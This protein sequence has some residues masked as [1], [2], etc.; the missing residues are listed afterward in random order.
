MYNNI[1]CGLQNDL[2]T[3][4]FMFM[5]NSLKKNLLWLSFTKTRFVTNFTHVF[6]RRTSSNLIYNNVFPCA[7]KRDHQIFLWYRFFLLNV[8]VHF[9]WK[10]NP[11]YFRS[12]YKIWYCETSVF[13][14]DFKK[15]ESKQCQPQLWGHIIFFET[16][17]VLE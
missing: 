14:V 6:P 16:P 2:I 9:R 1:F 15:V 13:F 3:I 4:K 11:T 8:F 12:M 17:Q 7:A 10:A 5:F